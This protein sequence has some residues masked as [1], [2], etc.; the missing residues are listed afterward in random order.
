MDI[1][2]IARVCH[3]ANRE[4]CAAVGDASQPPWDEAPEWQRKSAVEGVEYALAH[5]EATPEHQ[6]EAWSAAKV[7]DGWSHGPV[8]DAEKKTHPCLVPYA[9]LPPE[10][11]AKDALFQAVVAA[12]KD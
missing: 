11:R 2:I 7:A 5:P 3:G 1:E 12:L 10:Q 4:L 8:K 6:H 9:E